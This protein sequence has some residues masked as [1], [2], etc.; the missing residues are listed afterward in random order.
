VSVLLQPATSRIAP[1]IAAVKNFF[2]SI[3]GIALSIPLGC[4][5]I[6]EHLQGSRELQK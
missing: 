5:M 1:H 6:V 4:R 2:R 3:M